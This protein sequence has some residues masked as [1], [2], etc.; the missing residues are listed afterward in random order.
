MNKIQFINNSKQ[1]RY[2]LHVGDDFAYLQYKI[3]AR[4]VLYLVHTQTPYLLRGNGIAAELVEKSL[5]DI[6]IRD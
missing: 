4:G 3:D 1:S 6:K 2:E 5:N